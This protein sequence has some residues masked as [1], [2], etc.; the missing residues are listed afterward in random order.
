MSTASR[1]SRRPQTFEH[2]EQRATVG[3][4]ATEELELLGGERGTRHVAQQID[5]TEDV[6]D[7]TAQVV[8]ERVHHLVPRGVDHAFAR[9]HSV[10]ALFARA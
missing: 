8:I 1:A 2:F 5:E 9:C 10:P 7:R 6:G 3:F 4:D